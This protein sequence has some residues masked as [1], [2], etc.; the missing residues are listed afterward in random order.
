MLAV[1]RSTFHPWARGYERLPPDGRRHGCG[2]MVSST[3]TRTRVGPSPLS[4]SPR[5]WC[6]PPSV[7]R[8]CPFSGCAQP[9][10]S[11]ATSSGSRTPSPPGDSSPTAPSC[12]STTPTPATLRRSGHGGARVRDVLDRSQAGDDVRSPADKFGVPAREIEDA[13]RA[14]SSQAARPT[15][16][17]RL[18]AATDRGARPAT[19]PSPA[20]PSARR[21]S[22]ST[23]GR[24]PRLGPRAGA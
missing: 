9:S 14:A 13:L 11:S 7:E 18:P 22:G 16:R 23:P 2:P 1:P 19:P 12:S 24:R 15:P 20:S 17:R 3:R 5:T 10:T 8:T 4:E 6:S 21:P